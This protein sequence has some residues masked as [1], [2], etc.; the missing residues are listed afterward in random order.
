MGKQ[1]S[2]TS[3]AADKT[4]YDFIGRRILDLYIKP[5]ETININE[6][7]KFLNVSRSPI[8]DAL[9]QLEKEG[10][11]VTTP[12]KGT[13]V[14]KINASRVKDE[15]FLRSCIEER[16]MEEF[17]EIFQESDI[18]EMRNAIKAQERAVKLFDAREFLACD[19]TMHSIPFK[20]TGHQ[21]C[22]NTVLNMS[23]H[24]SRIRL[25]SLSDMTTLRQT[26]EQHM[27]MIELIIKKDSTSLKTLIHEH[28]TNKESEF[29]S[30]LN[31]Y[32][33]LFETEIPTASNAANIWE[34]DFLKQKDFS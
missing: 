18:E 7:E 6:L 34:S 17:L 24:Y 23:G 5:G 33:D 11:V 12:K 13:I 32:P 16:V 8:R 20:V 9:I 4:V 3:L 30:L 14:S 31:Q 29:Q 25:L 28:I 26:L 27:T 10:L 22:L 2:Q 19:D 1:D 21:F 15:R